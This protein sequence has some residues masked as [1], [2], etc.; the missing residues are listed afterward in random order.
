MFRRC[1]CFEASASYRLSVQVGAG[2]GTAT[3][4]GSKPSRTTVVKTASKRTK[5][6]RLSAIGGCF[7]AACRSR[8]AVRLAVLESWCTPLPA[9]PAETSEIRL[10][11]QTISSGIIAISRLWRITAP[12]LQMKLT[13]EQSDH[14]KFPIGCEEDGVCKT[15][16]RFS[17]SI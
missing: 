4:R 2:R 1:H 3:D 11:V 12:L 5:T 8:L 14:L 13:Q 17:P 6:G 9:D 10:C 16:M 7:P 15:I